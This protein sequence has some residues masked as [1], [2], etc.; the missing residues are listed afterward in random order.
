MGPST[1]T[2]IGSIFSSDS[3]PGHYRRSVSNDT[4]SAHSVTVGKISLAH[5]GPRSSRRLRSRLPR[6]LPREQSIRNTCLDTILRL[7]DCKNKGKL[8]VC[9]AANERK[10]STQAR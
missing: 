8:R 6:L 4:L 9:K 7:T 1:N 3:A 5:V 2:S 10:K